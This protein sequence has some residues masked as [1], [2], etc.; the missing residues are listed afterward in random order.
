MARSAILPGTGTVLGSNALEGQ[1][2]I[3]FS[4]VFALRSVLTSSLTNEITA[5]V[6]GGTSALGAGLSPDSYGLWN[7]YQ[8][9][10]AGYITNPYN[11]SYTGFA[12]RKR[13]RA[14][15]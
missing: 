6:L 1:N 3:Y 5:G 14:A 2:G 10:Y 13:S 8:T 11:G 15:D 9:S 12:P 4:G 7:G